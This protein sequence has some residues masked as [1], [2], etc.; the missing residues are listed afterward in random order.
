MHLNF[1][2][3]LLWSTGASEVLQCKFSRILKINNREMYRGRLLMG[4]RAF[5][6]L[7]HW[8]ESGMCWQ[9]KKT[10]T[11]WQVS[12]VCKELISHP[13]PDPDGWLPKSDPQKQNYSW[14]PQKQTDISC[15]PQPPFSQPALKC[16]DS[17]PKT[18]L[19]WT[20]L[21]INI[22]VREFQF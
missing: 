4:Y 9:Q 19:P 10:I 1:L 21:R 7:G 20:V 16:S 18:V 11:F 22:V 6:P 3:L 5:S 14:Q 15:L 8:F 12:E 17:Q 13:T 2:C